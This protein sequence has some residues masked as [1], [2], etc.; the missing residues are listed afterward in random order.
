MLDKFLFFVKRFIPKPLFE[1][2]QPKYHLALAFM[3]SL[4]YGFPSRSLKVIGL[5]G[6]SGK[7]TT[8]EFLHEIFQEAVFK[9]ASAS[10]LRFKILEREEP[11]LLKMTTPGRFRIQKFLREAQRAGCEYVFLEIT[12]QGI[13]QSRH[14]FIKFYAALL[15][16]LSAEHLEA[17]GGFENYRE[18]KAKL[19]YA[20]PLHVLNADD[21]NFDFFSEIPARERIG[22]KSSDFPPHLELALKGEF[23]KMNALAAITFAKHEGIPYDVSKRALEKITSIPGRMEFIPTAKNFQVLVDYAF[24]PQTLEPVY[25]ILKGESTALVCVLGAAGGGRDKWKRP[26]LGDVAAKYCR[27]VFVTN[28][29]PYDEEPLKIMNEVCGSH[30]FEKILDRRE[31]VREALKSAR[32]GES[33]VITGK[34]AEPWIMG[35]RG[36]KIPWDD[37][38]M[39]RE[40]LSKI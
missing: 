36:E 3:A 10:G 32:S 18:A 14:R 19:F 28:E 5:T 4:L 12:S 6:T 37:R 27:K 21:P 33:V 38:R 35:S 17:H 15:T 26:L 34:G 9:T 20:A 29:D 25:K 11:N 30:N 2:F 8:I 7:T 13:L 31:A 23:N 16:N 40:E 24:L 39:V 1:Y 22:F